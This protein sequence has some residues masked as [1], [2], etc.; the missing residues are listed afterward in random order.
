MAHMQARECEVITQI[1]QMVNVVLESLNKTHKIKTS[2]AIVDS[3]I[4][5][6]PH[7]SVEI[8]R[9]KYQIPFNWLILHIP[10]RLSFRT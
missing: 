10:N 8:E 5:Q 2:C 1:N 6:L 4:C 9:I 7:E 3:I